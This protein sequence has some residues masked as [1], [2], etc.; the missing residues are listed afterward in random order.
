[1]YPRHLGLWPGCDEIRDG[2]LKRKRLSISRQRTYLS[3][4]LSFRSDLSSDKDDLAGEDGER[5][6]H[7]VDGVRQAQHLALDSDA[8]DLLGEISFSDGGGGF[9][10]RSDL[11]G[12][13]WTIGEAER[14]ADWTHKVSMSRR[15]TYSK[16]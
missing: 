8:D 9:R 6:D 11:E 14:L 4:K 16:P 13:I 12:Q 15:R 5:V 1:M 7:L 3:S 2:H 10:D